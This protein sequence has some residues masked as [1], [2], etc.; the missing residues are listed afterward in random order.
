MAKNDKSTKTT[1]TAAVD[2]VET[3]VEETTTP[4]VEA[5]ETTVN[6]APETPAVAE[7]TATETVAVEMTAADKY[8]AVHDILDQ[9]ASYQEIMQ[10]RRSHPAGEGINA[11]IALFR[12]IEVVLKSEGERFTQGMNAVIEWF[13]ANAQ[14]CT[15]ARYLYRYFQDMPL[16][17]SSRTDFTRLMNLFSACALAYPNLTSVARSV[18]VVSSVQNYPGLVQSRIHEFFKIA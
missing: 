7:V 1:S 16:A 3:Q 2:T 13:A 12:S 9:L 15:N 11:Q 14:G 8:P 5:V 17:P 6:D 10:P 4:A 18:D